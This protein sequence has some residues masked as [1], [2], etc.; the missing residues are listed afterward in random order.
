MIRI[1]GIG[2]DI[3]M[4]ALDLLA[5]RLAV[6]LRLACH[7]DPQRI[8]PNF[9]YD[10]VRNQ[11]HATAILRRLSHFG[12]EGRVLGVATVDLYVPIFTFVFGEAQLA[13]PAALISRYRL[14][15]QHYGLPHDPELTADRLLKEALHE[16]G[17]TFGLRHCHDWS[18]PMAS[19]TS[20][21]RLDLKKSSLC[22]ACRDVVRA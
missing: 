10:A 19:S 17:H 14:L 21:E 5:A 20:V 6:E 16:L 4:E 13:G 18:C 2:D 12:K 15:Q 1:V 22:A 9:A 8:D 7:V 11:H 3:S